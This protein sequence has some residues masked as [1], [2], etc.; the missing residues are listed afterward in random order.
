MRPTSIIFYNNFASHLLC[1]YNPNMYYP[2]LP[3]RW[4]D[5]DW[6]TCVRMLAGFGFTTFEFWLE[7]R[8]FCREALDS[9]LGIEYTR[10]MNAVIG[11]THDFGMKTELITGLATSGADWR[12]LCPNLDDEWRT[13][14]FLWDAWTKRFTGLDSVGIFPGDPGAC[15]RHGC[16]AETYID[17]SVEIAGLIR[18]NLPRA[19]VEFHT[20][21]PPFFGWG[22]IHMGPESRGEFI[23]KDQASAWTFSKE[24]AD[25][26]MAHVLAR[27]KDFPEGTVVAINLG[28]N[29]DGNPGGESDARAWAAAIAE[30]NPIRTWDYSL[31][32]GE[33]TVLPHYRFDRLFERRRQE[34]DAAPYSGGICYSMTPMLNQLTAFEAARSFRIPDSDPKAVAEE[35]FTRLFGDAGREVVQYFPLFEAMPGWGSYQKCALSRDEYHGKMATLATILEDLKPCV[36]DTPFHPSV[37]EYRQEILFFARLCADLSG[38]SPDYDALRRAYWDRVYRIYDALPGHPDPR[39]QGATDE[40]IRFFAQWQ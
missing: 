39:A 32:E 29:S 19:E 16:T 14:R 28:F 4:S 22:I 34:R 8:M 25:K 15:S 21:G 10:Q 37:D 35:F 12:T 24:R 11:F 23:G 38:P 26:S 3:H 9:D 2:G 5:E 18:R 20:W 13:I 36:V 17:K 1:A 33:G 27:L 40:L 31:T 30:T 7:P 6:K